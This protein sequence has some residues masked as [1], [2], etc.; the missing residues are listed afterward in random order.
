MRANF[1]QQGL[2]YLSGIC[3]RY[4][5]CHAVILSV[6]ILY[7]GIAEQSPGCLQLR[8][9]VGQPFAVHLMLVDA[10]AISGQMTR[11]GRRLVQSACHSS[12][13]G[14]RLA[15]CLCGGDHECTP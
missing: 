14:A 5:S 12:Y 10:L 6:L 11:V 15:Q 7:L 13:N 8:R 1:C 4:A 2:M 3:Q 9:S